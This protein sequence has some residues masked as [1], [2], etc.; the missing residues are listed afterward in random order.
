MDFEGLFQL[1]TKYII[2]FMGLP[3]IG[4]IIG[5]WL[6]NSFF[7]FRLKRREWRWEKEL[8]ARELLFE[9]V[10]RI[11]FISDH[12]FKGEYED[13][14]SMTGIGMNEADD[15][16]TRLVKELHTSGHKLK[17]HLNKH[18][19]R[20]FDK[21]LKESQ[22]EYDKA[23]D[24]WGKWHEGDNEAVI[25]HTEHTIANQGRVALRALSE[26]ELFS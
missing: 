14:F 8:W 13:R 23:K 20:V 3:L 10:S 6:T 16:I 24:T 15:E 4:V 19:S 11:Q 2:P 5:A 17:L 21:Y 25:E 12:Y 26:F 18:N 7:P 22:A 9:T 1:F